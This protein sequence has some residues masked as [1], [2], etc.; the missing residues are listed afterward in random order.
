MIT[1]ILFFIILGSI[2]FFHE[3]GHFLFAK[4]AGAYVHEFSLGFGPKIFSF[5]RKNDET[6]YSIRCFPL[7]GYVAIAG[8]SEEEDGLEKIPD[9]KKL[10][11]KSWLQR[12]FVMI[13]GVMNNFILGFILLFVIGLMNGATFTSNEID[14]IMKDY[15]LYEAGVRDGDKIVKINDSK[16]KDYDDIQTKIAIEGGKSEL[17]ITILK[18]DG[19]EKT[20]SLKPK[21][22]KKD[23]AYF[24]G[25]SVKTIHEKGIIPSLKYAS[26]KFKSIYKQILVVL[27]CL[28]TGDIGLNS[29]S[30]P[31]G[32]YSVVGTA[33]SS[34]NM[35]L[36]LTA[37][38]SINVGFMNLLPFPAFDGGHVLFLIIEK[39]KGSKVNPKLE[40]TL[41]SI[42]F[43]LLMLLMIVIT[44]KDVINLF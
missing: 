11:N 42:G 7:G 41:N 3:L 24:Y 5:K 34:L 18:T 33:K 32:I 44:V 35:I 17:D 22:S 39:I 40:A 23:K 30:G 25:I 16:M 12:L 13:A 38:L 2:V 1:L 15:P 36:Y 4:K 8:E 26:V 10:Y 20:V 9:N 29:L 21:Y 37:Y 43:M 19:K 27:K 31:V 14:N 6:E 28:F